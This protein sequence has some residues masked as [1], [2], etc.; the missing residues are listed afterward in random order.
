M[1]RIRKEYNLNDVGAFALDTYPISSD[2][3]LVI[4][5]T[6]VA[7]QVTQVPRQFLKHTQFRVLHRTLGNR[8][9]ILL[10][11]KEHKETRALFN[12]GFSFQTVSTTLPVI[13]D[14]GEVFVTQ[15]ASQTRSDPFILSFEA[16]TLV[17][18]L[19][20]I[21][22]VG[23][24][25]EMLSQLQDHPLAKL[26]LHFESLERTG[27]INFS[28][29][30]LNFWRITRY[31]L[32]EWR[33]NRYVENLVRDKWVTLDNSFAKNT[34]ENFANSIIDQ[35]LKKYRQ[36]LD[37]ELAKAPLP[38]DMLEIFRDKLVGL[39]ETVENVL[40]FA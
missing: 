6:E 29:E 13:I 40:T 21:V 12:P 20:I 30:K 1:D 25:I 32:A 5:A 14:D 31:V 3:P 33:L 24:G 17:L 38:P 19:D 23:V 39:C 7:K 2:F 34:Q 28:P 27:L 15:L 35:A 16:R 37:K 18:M 22:R 36:S 8:G 4:Y 10:E 11:G 26:W 9:L